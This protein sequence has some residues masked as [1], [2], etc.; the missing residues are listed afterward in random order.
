[1]PRKTVAAEQESML[2]D[3]HPA[4]HPPP[5]ERLA[6]AIPPGYDTAKCRVCPARVIWVKKVD[7]YGNLKLKGNGDPVREPL[8]THPRSDG[9]V[10][11]VGR[12]RARQIAPGELVLAHDR[13]TSHWKTCPNAKK[14]RRGGARRG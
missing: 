11:L 9:Q 4:Y 8:D 6:A 2:G 3:D 14:V 13:Y 10:M 1:M 5:P 12:G 7:G